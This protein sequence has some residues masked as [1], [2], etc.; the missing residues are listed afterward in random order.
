MKKIIKEN[1]KYFIL[2]ALIATIL[3]GFIY[4]N[5]SL[6]GHDL[7]FHIA[8]IKNIVDHDLKLSPIMP[9]LGNNL[10]YGI[11]IF[12]P[13]LPHYTYATIG[14]LLKIFSIPLIDSILFTNILVSIFSSIILYFLSLKLSKSKKVAFLSSIIYLLFPYRLGTITV[15]MAINENFT[16]LFM[17][18]ILLGI[19][20]LLDD[21]EN[22]FLIY[23]TVGYTGLILSHYVLSLYFTL[24]VFLVL[25]IN[26]KK[27]KEKNIFKTLITGIVFV[28]ILV[29]PNMILFLEHYKMDYLVY[30]DGYMTSSSL[31]Q[32]NILFLKDLFI[33]K[34][35]YDWDIPY[36]ISLPVLL[37]FI[38]STYIIVK[39]KNKKY[40][41]M[42]IM[43][44]GLIFLVTSN[45]V[46]HYLP[47]T[48]EMIQFP[49][50][51]LL[52]LSLFVSLVSPLWICKI[53]N[54]KIYIFLILIFILPS[55]F[56]VHK[57]QKRIY[58]YDYIN[59]DI[60]DGVGNINE[61]YPVEKF[62]FP[63]YFE[64]KTDIDFIESSGTSKVIEND[65][66]HNTYTFEI[67][68]DGFVK[69]ELP[70]IYY[71]GY[72][73]ENKKH[74]KINIKRSNYGFI[75]ADVSEGIYTLRYKGTIYDIIAQWLRRIFIFFCISKWIIV[76]KM[77]KSFSKKE[78]V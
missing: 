50:R 40:L 38:Y 16:G 69:I 18:L 45:L 55:F 41:L 68:S 53:K 70:R 64:N 66:N 26:I 51:L 34:N 65:T 13:F 42:I 77:N 48:F 74:Q 73:L 30:L 72:V 43:I 76:K 23:F 54:K 3:L 46:W 1:Y 7:S 39:N 5:D 32:S 17:P 12:Y 33:P 8:N 56:L 71:K 63:D 2:I 78:T 19:S 25:L 22:K 59:I 52:I 27:I 37:S 61:Y 28:S 21:Q 58:T 36:Y 20:N 47:S 31:I 4:K 24:L 49:W 9:E 67:E 35:N 6:R 62:Y 57:L 15:R 29:L 75:E 14:Y 10:G 60:N 44:I 11:Y